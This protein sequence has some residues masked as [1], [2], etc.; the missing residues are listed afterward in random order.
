DLIGERGV[1]AL[2]ALAAAFAANALSLALTRAPGP[3]GGGAGKGQR[4]WPR[5]ASGALSLPLGSAA[6][7]GWRM[8]RVEERRAEAPTTKIA[9]VHPGIEARERW[10]R[11]RAPSI[12]EKL[13]ALTKSAESRGAD[14]T[15]WPEAAYPY[16]VAHASRLA[17]LGD[18]AILGP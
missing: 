16:T 11:A 17:P 14:L 18:Y 4:R 7:G 2:M 12:L 6:Y 8:A 13:H 1:T 5:E 15:V 10:E 9:L 3:R